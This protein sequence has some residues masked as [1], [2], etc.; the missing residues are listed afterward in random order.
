MKQSVIALAIGLGLLGGFYPQNSLAEIF[1]SADFLK[2]SVKNQ[3]FYFRTSIGMAGLV[4]GRNDKRQGKCIDGWYFANQDKAHE[5]IVSVM[6][7][8][9]AFHPRGVIL[10]ILEKKCGKLLYTTIKR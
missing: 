7:K 8:H 9:P 4:A 1:K 6:E 5:E 3:S 2:W 10:A